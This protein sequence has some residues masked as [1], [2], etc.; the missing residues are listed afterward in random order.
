MQPVVH[1]MLESHVPPEN[2][3]IVAAQMREQSSILGKFASEEK[4]VIQPG[5]YHTHTVR[6]GILD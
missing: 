2:A 1:P 6:V 3:K 5:M 4:I